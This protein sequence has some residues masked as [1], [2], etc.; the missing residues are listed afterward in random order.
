MKDRTLL[1]LGGMICLTAIAISM[2]YFKIDGVILTS[3][4]STITGLSGYAIGR[5]RQ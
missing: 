1:A 2:M 5:K 4:I 3:I